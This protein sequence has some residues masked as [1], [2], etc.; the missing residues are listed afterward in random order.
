[1]RSHELNSFVHSDAS[2]IKVSGT[3]EFHWK[4][5]PL[6]VY[7]YVMHTSHFISPAESCL[8]SISIILSFCLIILGMSGSSRVNNR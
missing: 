7:C 4:F 3:N 2:H 6:F 1:M 8:S 5:K